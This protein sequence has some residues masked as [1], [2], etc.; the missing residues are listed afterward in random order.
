[1][2]NTLSESI[3]M[4]SIRLL[5]VGL[6]LSSVL[7][8]S[9]GKTRAAEPQL[10][11]INLFTA[12]ENG[13]ALYRIPGVV[14]TQ[15]GTVLAYCEA[16]VTGKGDW[17]AI[18]IVLRRST[19][20]G[21]S[22]SAM[23]KLPQVDGPKE[24]NPAA[25]AQ[26]LGKSH[27]FTYNNPVA[28]VDRDGSVHFIF[29]L[30][31]QRGFYLRSDDDGVSWSKPV[32]ISATFEQ[33]RNEYECNVRATG[34]AHG[35]QLRSGRLVVP[36]WLSTGKGGHAHRPS[37]TATIY[38]DDHG[39]TWQ[40]GAIAIPNTA[41]W[42][43]PNETVIVELADGRVMLNARSESQAN[44][45]LV[46]TSLDGAA[47]WST[48][49]FDDALWE[50]I[51]MGS[52]VR[53]SQMSTADKNRLVF[54]NPHSLLLDKQGRGVPAGRGERKNLSIKLSYDEGQSWHVNKAL[55]PG[56]SGYSDLAV[57]AD[58][59]VLCLYERS[60]VDGKSDFNTATLTLARF[61]LEWLTDGQDTLSK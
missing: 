17:D 60:S 34:P 59:T 56:R 12:G 52:I 32:E 42:I 5:S 22:W 35:I 55:E 58:G 27:E 29:C 38:S 33:F 26:G 8:G 1:M 3:I 7:L 40:R 54:A 16:R 41:E 2:L 53:L 9:L 43:N 45:R 19:D 30:E 49:R 36:V 48:P 14:V 10:D 50:P 57:L 18:D 24:K 44:R 23:V 51:C 11:K 31:Y 20:G 4:R 39:R 25:V 37:V 47:N 28:I 13:Y 6:V 21:K 61:N 46:T 15:R